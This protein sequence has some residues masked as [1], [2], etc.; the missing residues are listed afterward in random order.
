LIFPDSK[1][2]WKTKEVVI[3]RKDNYLGGRI[4]SLAKHFGDYLFF[5]PPTFNSMQKIKLL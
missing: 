3:M 2:V 1:D 5:F 4:W